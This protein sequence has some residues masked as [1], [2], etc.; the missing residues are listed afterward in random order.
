MLPADGDLSGLHTA[1]LDSME[2]DTQSQERLVERD[3]PCNSLLSGSF[4][5]FDL[6]F[7]L[8]CWHFLPPYSYVVDFDQLV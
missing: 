4:I 5:D 1:S 7:F 6:D 3:D 2:E 8:I